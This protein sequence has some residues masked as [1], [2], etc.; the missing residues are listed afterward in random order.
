MLCCLCRSV[1]KVF[2]RRLIDLTIGVARPHHHIRLTKQTKMGL[3]VW[4]KFLET[5]SGRAFFLTD[6]FHTDG[7]LDLHTDASGSVGYGVV[8]GKECF[9][10][11]MALNMVHPAH[12]SVR[13]VPYRGCC[14]RLEGGW[15]NQK[16]R[17]FTDNEALVSVINKQTSRDP[18]IMTLFRR[19]IL[20]CLTFNIKVM[21]CHVPG[22]VNSLADSL[23]R[24]QLDVFRLLAPWTDA[25]PTN[26]P[27]HCLPQHL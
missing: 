11:K 5:F 7:C 18:H 19:M 26:L 14:S 20:T 12:C 9:F 6:R 3:T 13:V 24:G 10:G 17:F 1:W 27:A 15:A 22:R 2:L 21:A 25:R 4:Q 23:S 8:Y 16:V